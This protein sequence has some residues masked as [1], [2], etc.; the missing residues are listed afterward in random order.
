MIEI[1]LVPDVKQELIKA[2]N[3]RNSV[4]S[5]AII[6]SIVAAG[7]VTLLAVWVFAVQGIRLNVNTGSIEDKY[8]ELQA[9]SDLPKILTIQNQLTKLG[10]LNAAKS[11]D[12]RIFNVL[13]AIIPPEPNRVQ[14]SDL[15][16]D[17]AESSITIQGQA[18]NSY[19]ALEIFKKTVEGMRFTYGDLTNEE[20]VVMASDI[21]TSDV[22]YGEDSSGQRVLRFTLKFTYAAELF[23]PSSTGLKLFNSSNGNVTDS[24]LGLPKDVFVDQASDVEGE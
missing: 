22:T 15:S 16:I 13:A 19:Q 21:I 2:Q 23:A 9:N 1:N 7:V 18:V 4:I 5:L 24:Y 3:A 11:M 17:Q 20:A 8:K 14:I 6:I 10:E 12:S